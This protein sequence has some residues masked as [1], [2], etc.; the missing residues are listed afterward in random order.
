MNSMKRLGSGLIWAAIVALT[1]TA[2][3]PSGNENN[4]T[5][6]NTAGTQPPAASDQA[7]PD[8]SPEADLNWIGTWQLEGSGETRGSVIAITEQSDKQLV[9]TL[10][11]FYVPNPDAEEPTPNIGNIQEGVAVLDIHTATFTDTD[12]D[13]TLTITHTGDGLQVVS[14]Q[15]TGY[16]GH[17][18]Q[19]DGV[20]HKN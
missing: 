11:A 17:G 8:A 5:A 15:N 1:L 9:F 12:L 19:V 6:G 20:Y 10:D 2:C 3:S 18:V 14:S 13:F 7:S 4:A 16:F